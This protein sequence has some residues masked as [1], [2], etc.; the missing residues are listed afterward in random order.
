MPVI[1]HLHSFVMNICVLTING[2]VAMV[3]SH[4]YSIRSKQFVIHLFIGQ[5][6]NDETD[7]HIG[8]RFNIESFCKNLRD[9]N[10]MCEAVT[11]YEKSWW[12][13]NGGYCLPY[14]LAYQTLHL[15]TTTVTNTCAFS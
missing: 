9:I 13:I 5:C 3:S 1:I 11:R 2:R 6:V 7:R 4:S 10:Y 8:I 14:S 12:T 15:D